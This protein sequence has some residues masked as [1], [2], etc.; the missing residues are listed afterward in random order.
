MFTTVEDLK[1]IEHGQKQLGGKYKCSD[2]ELYF[3]VRSWFAEA[4]CYES[5][6]YS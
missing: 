6:L 4:R 5:S 1:Q 2:L 3:Y